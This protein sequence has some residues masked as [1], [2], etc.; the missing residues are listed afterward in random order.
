MD[1]KKIGAFLKQCRKEKNLTQEQ[2]AEVLGVSARTVSRWETGT[3]MPD[4]SILV[5]LAEYYEVEMKELLDGERSQT[6]NKEMKETLDRVADYENWV[7]QKALKAGNLAFASMFLISVGAIIIQLLL[8]VNLRFVLGETLI[9]LV[10]GTVYAFIMIHNGIWDKGLSV[11]YGICLRRMGASEKQTI[12]FALSF[13]GGITIVA[14]IVLRILSYLNQNRRRN[15]VK[16]RTSLKTTASCT[17]IYNAKDIVEAGKIIEL[18]KEHGITAFSQEASANVAM[19]G[20]SGF[21]IYGVDVFVETDEAEK[22]M[23]ILED[24]DASISK[25]KF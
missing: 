25:E 20:M 1:T 3:N 15:A 8:T 21:G 4:L 19:H 9:A 13:L 11:F 18:F 22:A 24:M 12:H 6:M 2:L 23:Q 17:K 16:E 14:F 10:G 5:E 7:K